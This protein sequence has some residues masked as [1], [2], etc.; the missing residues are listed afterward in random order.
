M[1]L[2]L[3]IIITQN[4]NL[5]NMLLEVINNAPVYYEATVGVAAIVAGSVAVVASTTNAIMSNKKR[6]NA[7]EAKEDMQR[8]IDTFIANR[9]PVIDNSDDIRAL[10]EQVTNP[11]ANLGVATQAAE[12]QAEEADMAL[13]QTLDV[14]ASTGASAGGATALARAAL[15]SKRGIA[16]SIEQQEIKNQAM[17]AKG[18]QIAQQQRLNLQLQAEAE[19]VSAFDRQ[20][21]RDDVILGM[22]RQD[23]VFQA[24]LEQQMSMATQAAVVDT[25]SAT[26]NLAGGVTSGFK[27]G[28]GFGENAADFY[29]Y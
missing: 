13:A 29:G 27:G 22:K 3:H 21:R 28:G 25:I 23:E 19:E 15:Q 6:K 1:K 16:A 9:Q 2:L 24:N 12:F 18:E 26:G 7:A 20:E 5:I 4:L 14:V 11:Y 10:A 17:A 8:E